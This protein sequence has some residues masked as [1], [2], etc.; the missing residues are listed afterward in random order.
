MMNGDGFFNRTGEGQQL[1][2]TDAQR[3][4][5]TMVTAVIKCSEQELHRSSERNLFGNVG[6]GR[7]PSGTRSRLRRDLLK[8]RRHHSFS[9]GHRFFSILFPQ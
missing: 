1:C 2:L 5:N 7:V 3:V 4:V 8:T 6:T 9:Q